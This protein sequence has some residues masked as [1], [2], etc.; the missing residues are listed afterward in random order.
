LLSSFKKRDRIQVLAEILGICRNPQT[1]TYIRRQTGVSYVVLQSS[2]MH[3]LSRQWLIEVVDESGHKGLTTTNQGLVFLEK[4]AEI[5]SLAGF[6]NKRI[7]PLMFHEL[8]T[9]KMVCR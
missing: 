2:I 4:F 3:L 7:L 6:K 8:Q 1:Q 5:E 9:F